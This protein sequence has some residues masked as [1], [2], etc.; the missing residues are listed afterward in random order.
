MTA[1]GYRPNSGPMP[2]TKYRPRANKKAKVSKV[3][4]KRGRPPKAKVES[5]DC[6]A[7]IVKEIVVEVAAKVARPVKVKKTIKPVANIPVD[8]IASPVQVPIAPQ[9]TSLAPAD[10]A[11]AAA[12]VNLT[13][14]DYLLSVMNNPTED[15]NIRIRV[16]GM[17]APFIHPKPG[18]RTG[19]K[20]E[21][22]EKAQT[23]FTG[24]FKAG[25]S[26][27]SLVK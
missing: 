22:E 13:P 14:L 20:D 23:A 1:G 26:P 12:A 21:K 9:P 7:D 24:K 25:R 17:I 8:V 27:L 11:N 6:V 2:G 18:E 16:A 4:K 19:K 15:Q 3:P 5:A 10:I